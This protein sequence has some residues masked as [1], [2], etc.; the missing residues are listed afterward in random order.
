M[1]VEYNEGVE[2]GVKLTLTKQKQIK[3]YNFFEFNCTKVLFYS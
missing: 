1:Y 3:Y 2:N